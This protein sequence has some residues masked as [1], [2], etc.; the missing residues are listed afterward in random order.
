VLGL[1]V[2]L[3]ATGCCQADPDPT[4]SVS[5]QIA[6]A[7]PAGGVVVIHSLRLVVRHAAFVDPAGCTDCWTDLG[8]GPRLVSVPLDGTAVPVGMEDLGAG[9]Y[10]VA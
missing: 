2:G 7:P 6:A 9:R 5:F 10:A 3:A 8:A 4:Q 1:V